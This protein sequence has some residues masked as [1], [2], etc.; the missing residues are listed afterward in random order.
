MPAQ[1]LEIDVTNYKRPTSARNL[2]NHLGITSCNSSWSTKEF[3]SVLVFLLG[4]RAMA[5]EQ[6]RKNLYRWKKK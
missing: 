2:P 3:V 1:S 6:E 5:Q 4:G